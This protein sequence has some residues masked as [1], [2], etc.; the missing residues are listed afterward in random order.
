MGACTRI[1]KEKGKT[2]GSIIQDYFELTSYKPIETVL[3]RKSSTFGFRKE[4]RYSPT[5]SVCVVHVLSKM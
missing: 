3:E 1:I 2:S 4:E 5:V